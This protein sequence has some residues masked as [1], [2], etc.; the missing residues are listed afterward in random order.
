MKFGYLKRPGQWLWT[1]LLRG[2][3]RKISGIFLL[4]LIFFALAGAIQA[5][6]KVIGGVNLGTLPDYLLFYSNGSVDAN[7]QGATKGFVGNVAVDGIQAA[8]RTSGGVPYAGTIYTNDATL[9]AWQDIVDQNPGQ[10]FASTGNTAL[11]SG[12]EAD[13]VSAFQQINAL[14][15]TTGYT[16]VSSSALD[17]LNTQNSINEVFVINITSG[18]QVS[19]QLDV[20]GDA[21]DIYILRWDTDA[22][23]TNGY[24][25]QVKF[26][27]GGAIVPHGGLKPTNFISVA[28]DINSSGGGSN[29]PAPY[30][31]GPRYSDGTGTLINGGADFSGGG[32]FTGYWLTTGSPTTF[33]PASGLWY[34]E[35]APLSNGIFVGGW[36]SITDK[37]SMTSGT[38]GVYVTPPTTPQPPTGTCLGLAAR[39]GIL[40]LDNGTV[41]I[42]SATNLRAWVGYSDGVTSTTNQKVN[43]FIGKVEVHSGATFNYTPATFNPSLGIYTSGYDDSLDIAN[44]D[45][46]FASNNFAGMPVDQTFGAVTNDLTINRTD[47]IT[48]VQMGS[49]NYNSKTLTLVGLPG[50]DDAFVINV[51]GNFTFADSKIVLQNV[52]PERVVFNFPNNSTIDLYKATNVFYGTILAPTSSVTYHNPATFEGAIIAK[53]INLHSDFN[54]TQRSLDIPCETPTTA[55][56][57]DFIWNDLNHNGIQDA[58]EPGI[59]NVTVQLYKCSDNTLVATTTTN[60]S[61]YYLFSNLPAGQY[62]VKVTA[63]SGYSITTQNVG[64]NDAVDSDIDPTTGQTTCYTLAAG[65]VNLTVDGGLYQPQVLLGSI[66]DFVWNDLNQ[67]GIQ[68]AGEP[69]IP[70]VPVALHDGTG[71]VIKTTVTDANGFYSFTSLPAG[72]YYVSFTPPSGYTI[73]PINQGGDDTKDSDI[74][75]DGNTTWITLAAGENNPTIDAGMYVPG[76]LAS[77]GDFV[78]KDLNNNGIQDSG[79]P[80]IAGVT[81]YLY[82]CNSNTVLQTTTT[83]AN[84]LYHFTGLTPG[85]YYVQFVLPSGYSYSPMNAGTNDA[86]D[87]D[88]DPNNLGKTACYTLASGETNNTVDAGLYPIPPAKASLG[89]FVWLDSN[90]NG[91]QDAGEQGLPNI[92]VELHLCDANHTLV[93]TTT[94]NASGIYSFTNL[95][96]GSYFIKVIKPANYTI[97]PVNQGSND[98]LDSDIGTDGQSACVTLAAGETNLTLDAGMYPTPPQPAAL[99]D[100]VWNDTNHNGIQD[101]GEPGIPN[102]TVYLYA[103][104]TTNVLQSTTT[105]S[106][107]SYH[108]TGLNP[109]SYYVQFVLPSGYTFTTPNAGADNVDS[110]ADPAAAGK[111]GCYTLVAGETNNTV[112]A[113]M[114]PI[115]PNNASLGDFVWNDVNQNGIQDAGELGIP[116]VTVELHKCSDNSLVATTTTNPSGI[117]SFTNLAPDGYYIKVIVPAGYSISPAYQGGDPAKDSNIGSDAKSACI[118]LAAGENNMTIDAGLYTTPPAPA[119]IGDFVWNDVNHNGIQDQGEAGIPGVTVYLYACNGNTVLQTTTTDASGFY[120]FTNLAPGGYYVQFVLPTGYTYSPMN[121]GT[122]DA[123]DSDADPNNLGKTGCYTLAP[124]E[125]NT[126]VDAGMYPTP[127]ALASLGDFVWLDTNHNGIQEAGELGLPNVTVQLF[128]CS[129]NSLVA[130]TTTNPNGM[131]LFS[132]LPAGDYY[133]KVTVPSGYSVS[134]ANQGTDDAKD[135]DI[136]ND[137]KTACVTLAAG[138]NNMTVDAGLYPTPPAPASIGDF[139]WNDT[140]HNGIQD[141]GEPGIS[142]VTVELYR[143]TDNSFVATTTTD[144][145]GAYH[146]TGLTPGGYYVKFILPSGYTFSPMNAGADNVDS[147][148]DAALGG[149]TACYTLAA[150]ET[151][152]TVDA[153]MYPTP[154]QTASLGDFIWNDLNHNG[155]QDAGEAGI[156]GVTVEL[157]KCS[158][159]SLVAT[160][161]TN[162]NGLYSFTNL[163]AGDYYIKVTVPAGYSISPAYQ[164]SDPTKDSNIGS[165][166]QS[167]CITLAAGE[168]NMT[169]DAGLYTTPPQTACIGDFVWN[170]ANHNGIQD[171]GEVG[172][173][174]IT[175]QL[176]KCSD[177]SLVAQT[178]SV[179]NGFYSFCD[180]PEGSYYV[181]FITTGWTVSPANQGGDD[182]KDSD[183]GADGKTACFTVVPGQNNYTVDAGL[184]PPTPGNNGCVGDFVWNDLNHN[185]IQDINEPGLSGVTVELHDCATHALVATTVTNTFG[186]YQFYNVPA[187]SY[188]IK[189]NVPAG[190]NVSPI[191]QGTND[192]KDSDI[193]GDG[194]SAC[195][196]VVAGVANNSVDAGLYTSP[197]NLACI[198]DFVWNDINRNGIQDQGEQGLFGVTVA[199]YRCS[200]NMLVAWTTT[201]YFGQY[202][203]PNVPA[204]DYYVKFTVPA[205]YTVS[206]ALQGGNQALDSNPDATG[207]TACFTVA[208]G[209]SNVTIDAGMYKTPSDK[210]SIGDFVW[211]DLN[212]NG[213]Q[214]ANEPGLPGVTVELRKCSDHSLVATTTTDATGHYAFANIPAGSYFVKVI[215]PSGYTVSPVN[216]GSNDALD[217]DIGNDGQTACFDVVG[218]VTNNTIDA[219]LI[220]PV[221]SDLEVQKSASKLFLQC[222]ENF[223]YTVTVKN[224][225]PVAASAVVVTDVEPA[226]ADFASATASQG[227][228][229]MGTGIW[230]V[231]N[232]A[233]GQTATLTLNAVVDCNELSSGSLNLGPASGY[234][235]F[236]LNDLNQTGTSIQGKAAIGGNATMSGYS[237]IGGG[238]AP[239]S[240]NVL[241]VGGNLT[242][243][244]GT[245]ENGNVT[246]GGTTNLP[247]P[248][249]TIPG[250]TLTHAAPV[251]FAAAQAALL[252]L[253]NALHGYG[254]NGTA[255]LQW[256]SLTLSGSDPMLNVF[257]VSG[258]DLSSSNNLVINVPNGSVVVVN[259]SGQ[260]LTWGGGMTVNGASVSKVIFNFF[261]AQTIKIQGLTVKGTILAPLAALEF[262]SGIIEGQAIV[263][264]LTGAGQFCN[265]PF[266]GN[267][268]ASKSFTNTAMLSSSSPADLIAGN[269]TSSV[270]VTVGAPPDGGGG[271]Q[272]PICQFD[273]RIVAFAFDGCNMYAAVEGGKVYRSSDGGKTWEPFSVG[274]DATF[275]W[276]LTVVNGTVFAATE[277]GVY[278]FNGTK[279]TLM[280]CENYDVHDLVGCNGALYAATWG[281]GIQ[282]SIDYGL[283]WLPWNTGFQGTPYI[284][285]LSAVSDY[286]YAATL[287]SGIFRLPC[288]GT[289]WMPFSTPGQSFS[290]IAGCQNYL[291][292]ASLIDGLFQSCD[293][294]TWNPVT[295]LPCQNISSIDVAPCG[296]VFVSSLMGGVFCSADHGATWTNLGFGGSDVCAV[297]VN[298]ATQE[299]YL[300]TK[301]G[302][303]YKLDASLTGVEDRSKVPTEFS[304]SQN[305][306]NPFNPSTTI[307]FAI[308]VAG[309]YT[310]KVY[311]MLGQEVTTLV[312]RELSVGYHKAVFD[313]SK[314]SSGMYIYR[315]TGTNVQMIRKMMLV[316]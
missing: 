122:N 160:T 264:S 28:G 137:G 81:V 32:F 255:A 166:A 142:G 121:A 143:C 68:D 146:F 140:N 58:G 212:G 171:A 47:N 145:N 172:I 251:D 1:H 19:D 242:M 98:A 149:R 312:N 161:T 51:L 167:A 226:G 253:S 70:G 209:T 33:D 115:P 211:R 124:G 290:M 119:S 18:F 158:D 13:L 37:F 194:Q 63:P 129:D 159:L 92:T 210:G 42:N 198:G 9:G 302:E 205:G 281:H 237:A 153:G 173:P 139:V 181:K 61:G 135:S 94:T 304:L 220:P 83:D 246:Y 274:L 100:F 180:I 169:I 14:P 186:H 184:Y 147:D 247:Q 295:T 163:P 306:P 223:T 150:G 105:A 133:V 7:W 117:Y 299:V 72:Q 213:I 296:R 291:Y 177:N 178:V 57:G 108:F 235:L 151:N 231:G 8:E 86:L 21:G 301:T 93:S 156:P 308:P 273:G 170:D 193:G 30:P 280:G 40:G 34:G 288:G 4:S 2:I 262:P 26:Q 283:N 310:L 152:N 27:S 202:S 266:S 259:I 62:Y 185:G 17:G 104:N 131:Y 10:A 176:Y 250:G 107:G 148:A 265:D 103:C 261:Q 76:Q 49:L 271:P 236:V 134:P 23:F 136:G 162:S 315:L 113:G 74:G 241:V 38:S 269:N 260:N 89:D 244:N 219:G 15:A 204:G 29:P 20:T 24:Q 215:I 91:I 182:A 123:L 43:N 77:L 316:K 224:L 249:V 214:D 120:H 118:T 39:Y 12:L 300:G 128:K 222:G 3:A 46:L 284:Q 252:S 191:N 305:Y 64:L 270:T 279:W 125:N 314:I 44:S 141:Q 96:P 109:G 229:D 248:N 239:N 216:Q 165:D 174:G 90:M 179:G 45:A 65:Q 272:P 144:A 80:G 155:I 289:D 157:H 25:G 294:S 188:Y 35:T 127:Q 287:G 233:V 111:T 195:F 87:S 75:P 116:N 106:D 168:N 263:K 285:C 22:N 78:W 59:Q 84:G 31:Q 79:E 313:A 154:Q 240:G 55:S 102:V 132:N 48:V 243:V 267:I 282:K 258:S 175:I 206:P 268:P 303:V 16:S 208:G 11:I 207:K 183:I 225:G 5:Q 114:Y 278:V 227:T 201:N 126:T 190:F 311:D 6:D 85:S 110:D 230:Q 293:G 71:A 164:G 307:E 36:Y 41:I 234:N 254:A 257:N 200:D 197:Q 221:T 277:K 232:L 298:P 69:G 256:G 192:E 73:S 276:G 66:G 88:A 99:G 112:D 275:I 245:V 138:E 53:N 238:L 56:L 292:A 228:Y 199:L 196:N 189:V 309:K 187:G 52:R 54:L 67:N 130:T 60:A 50:Q 95:D 286:I 97:S 203:F 297:Y 82:A 217:S 101:A 218:E